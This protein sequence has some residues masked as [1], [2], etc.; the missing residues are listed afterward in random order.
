MEDLEK[1]RIKWLKRA[2]LALSL[3]LFAMYL[4]FRGDYTKKP[5][6]I[7]AILNAPIIRTAI[8][9]L[10]FISVVVFLGIR[11]YIG[12]DRFAK[13]T[14]AGFSVSDVLHDLRYAKPMLYSLAAI[15]I[16]ELLLRAV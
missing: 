3:Q 11:Y 8:M 16:C 14:K 7:A 13:S 10:A 12:T 9:L 5:E 6:S 15:L 2:N 1:L 4:A